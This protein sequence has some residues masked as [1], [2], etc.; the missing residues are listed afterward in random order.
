M[1]SSSVVHLTQQYL[2][3]SLEQTPNPSMQRLPVTV[4]PSH[5]SE[6]NGW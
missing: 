4:S 6:Q 1:Q 3:K 5:C 2:T